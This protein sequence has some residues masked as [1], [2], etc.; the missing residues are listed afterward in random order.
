MATVA[1]RARRGEPVRLTD[2]FPLWISRKDTDGM[3]YSLT[4][5][6]WV[7]VAVGL[8]ASLWVVIALLAAVGILGWAAITAVLWLVAL[9]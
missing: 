1:E 7:P 6:A 8:A 9:L 4:V 5:A 3:I 2:D